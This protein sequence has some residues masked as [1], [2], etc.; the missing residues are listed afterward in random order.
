MASP[1]HSNLRIV[2]GVPLAGT[3]TVSGAKNAA[4][5]M[6]AATLLADG[7]VTLGNVP[8]LTDVRTMARLLEHLGV[9]VERPSGGRAELLFATVDGAPV[10][11]PLGLMR[12]MRAGLCVLGPLVARRGRAIVPLPGG[13]RIGDRPVDLHLK[14][15]AALGAEIRL[16]RGAIV[17]DARRLRGASIDLAGPAGPTVTGTANVLCAAVLAQGTTTL[18]GAAREPEIVD[19]GRLLQG[20][21]ACIDG[22]GSDTIRIEGVDRLDGVRHSIIPDRI[23]AATL[24]MAA[25]ITGG[26]VTLRKVVVEHL[27]PVV[28]LLRAAGCRVVS[29]ADTIALVAPAR[30]SAVDLTAEPFPGVPTDV[31]AQWIALMSLAEGTSTIRDCVFPSRFQHV[32]EL[33]RL[34]AQIDVR[35]GAATVSG[36]RHLTAAPLVASDLRASAALVLAGLAARGETTIAAVHHLDRGY[37]WLDSK[38]RHLG[39]NVTRPAAEAEERVMR[40]RKR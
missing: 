5:P 20:M 19:L 32:A 2:G 10:K 13:C 11:A 37:E 15:L 35:Q 9:R 12:L 23:E 27:T 8:Q 3:V 21:G 22:L 40:I 31:Q 14:G 30:L 33:R 6:M 34:G 28:D 29:T 26:Q 1:V 36:V 4:L 7:P 25:A 18:R 38:L 39:A 16:S 24:L 17:A